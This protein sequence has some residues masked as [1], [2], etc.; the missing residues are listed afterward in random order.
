MWCDLIL[1]E[2]SGLWS[3]STCTVVSYAMQCS[4]I[5]YSARNTKEESARDYEMYEEGEDAKKTN[6]LLLYQT[7][8]TNPD[9]FQHVFT[10]GTID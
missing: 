6:S 1:I 2:A 4:A 10:K 7:P 9:I 5:I 3:M 8:K